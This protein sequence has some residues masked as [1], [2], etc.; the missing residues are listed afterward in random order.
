[1]PFAGTP[2]PRNAITDVP[3][4]LVGHAT[5]IEGEG[6]AAVRTGVTAVLANAELHWVFAGFF[7]L[8]G[9]G[10]VSGTELIDEWGYLLSPV[11]LTNTISV[12]TVR[13]AVVRWSLANPSLEHAVNLPVVAETWDGRLNDIY[14][15]HVR[16]EH[17]RQALESASVD[18]TR[19]G[20]VGGGTGMVC[21]QFKGG[22]GTASRRLPASQGGYTLG[23]LV[24]ANHGRRG[25]LV[26]AGVAVGQRIPGLL[27]ELN[28]ATRP[29][30]DGSI[31]IVVATD[32]PLL[33]HQL[34]RV[35]RRT[36][37]GLAR[38]GSRGSTNSG[39]F[40]LAF[41]TQRPGTV[42]EGRVRQALFL[43]EPA[44][45]PLFRAAS[46]AT[47]EAIVNALVAAETMTGINGNRVHALPH[48]ALVELMGELVLDGS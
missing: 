4:V 3:G 41:S 20:N 8:N 26:I 38:T 5:I 24:Q 25:D 35:A 17:V 14:G 44:L 23:V 12:G 9:N 21:H 10:E 15:F 40:A 13:D 33:P 1:V 46:D 2:G 37:L 45:D 31:V 29:P 36:V 7:V 27:P 48:D 34:Q 47:E 39:D 30:G 19:E 22:I 18:D 28:Q 16:D 32:A 6:E 43:A 11:L 42:Q